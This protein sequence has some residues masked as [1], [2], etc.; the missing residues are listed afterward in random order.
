MSVLLS[1]ND[2]DGDFDSSY[3]K[4]R[5]PYTKH[6]NCF[7]FVFIHSLIEMFLTVTMSSLNIGVRYDVVYSRSVFL[8]LSELN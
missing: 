7:T 8:S 2:L 1:V 4:T 6:L 5:L 3:Q